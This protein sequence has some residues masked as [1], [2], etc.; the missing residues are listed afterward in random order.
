M[1]KALFVMQ[2]HD[3]C[4][5]E[6][7]SSTFTVLLETLKETGFVGEIITF[8]IDE[9]SQELGHFTM[10]EV[11]LEICAAEKPNLIIFI[12]TGWLHIDP[13]R[14]T[15]HTITNALGTK[16]YMVRDDPSGEEGKRFN[17]SW[18]SF[19]SFIGFIDVTVPSLGYNG[20]PKAV[21]AFGCLDSK[22]FYDKKLERDIDVSFAGSVGN[23]LRR[24]EYI[25][26]LGAN[27]IN[28]VTVGG[29]EYETRVPIEEYSDI[30]SRSKISLSFCLH[31]TEG[32]PQMKKRVFEILSCKTCMFEDAGIE[33]RKF[34]EPGK[35][36]VMY[37]SKEELLEKVL[38][39]LNHEEERER[40]AD[41][42][43]R[44]ATGLYSA[45]NLWGHIL[46]KTG[47]NLPDDVS[48][49]KR[50]QELSRKLALIR[51]GK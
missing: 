26:F 14:E 46:E 5:P 9:L 3:R 44:K 40:I 12:P 1:D 37:H 20:N 21:Q 28:V 32:F 49:D 41:S 51:N 31:R 13:S 35:D 34:F 2:K 30:I 6:W 25:R 7:G 19:V 16:V 10:D 29:L 45:R 47:F 17:E 4:Q 33:T 43:Y 22:N 50:Y 23:W 48:A 8:Y 39:Y 18:F 27:G 11:L 38:Y 36:F 42:G 15:M 24:D